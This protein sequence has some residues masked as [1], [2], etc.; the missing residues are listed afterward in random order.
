MAMVTMRIPGALE[1]ERLPL[2]LLMTGLLTAAMMFPLHLGYKTKFALDTA[3]IFAAILIFEPG[4]AMLIA[5]S[6]MLLAS[7]VH[8]EPWDQTIFNASQAALQA[9]VGGLI[10][11]VGGWDSSNLSLDRPERWLLILVAAGAMHVVNTLSVAT[12]IGLQ[13]GQPPLLIWRRSVGIDSVEHLSQLVLGL[14]TAVVADSHPWALPLLLVPALA[15]YRSTERNLLLRT[16]T[17]DAVEA[18]ADLVDMRDPYTADHSA[19]VACY[20]R[21]I[22][23]ALALSPDDV[24]LVERAA[25]VHDVGKVVVDIDVLTKEGRLTADEWE[26]LRRHPAT[27]AMILSR[28]P[29]FAV[30]TAFVR[31]HHERWDGKGYP[32]GLQGTRIPLGARIIAVADAFD[33]MAIARPYRPALPL[34]TVLEEFRRGRDLQW[35]GRVVDVLL[36]LLQNGRIVAPQDAGRVPLPVVRARV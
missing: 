34:E 30:A 36:D 9:G 13:S 15:V 33:A 35:D 19:R 22:A 23:T 12:I 6:G 3:V 27:G 20:A 8:R 21:E 10:L 18:L 14:L 5:A 31:H 25:R 32:D 26:Q 2:A 24:A 29:H 16:Q 28:F 1:V 7:A 4:T 17:L 11:A